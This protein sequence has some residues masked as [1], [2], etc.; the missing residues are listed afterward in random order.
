MQKV[1]EKRR[2]NY[3]EH[4]NTCTF[5]ALH[6]TQCTFTDIYYPFLEDSRKTL[7]TSYK[8]IVKPGCH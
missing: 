1:A 2:F 5:C 8:L 4:F 7:V 3:F 6:T